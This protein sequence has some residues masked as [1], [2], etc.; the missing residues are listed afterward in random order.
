MTNSNASIGPTRRTLAAILA[1]AL[2]IGIAIAVPTAPAKASDAKDYSATVVATSVAGTATD[3]FTVTFK[4]ET[5]NT[6]TQRAGSFFVDFGQGG[7]TDVS[8]ATPVA[9]GGQSW[10]L[11]S[12]ANGLIVISATAGGERIGVGETVSVDVQATAPAWSL[13][14]GNDKMLSTGGDQ[15]AYGDFGGGNEFTL[16][17]GTPTITVTFDG[18]FANCEQGKDCTTATDGSVGAATAEC[19]PDTAAAGDGCGKDGVVAIDFLEGICDPG[20]EFADECEAIWFADTTTGL[21]AG[22]YFY[23]VI[24]VPDGVRNPTLLFENTFGDLEAMKNCQPPKRVFNCVDIKH[25]DYDKSAGIYP[26]K[27][28]AEDPRV[29]FG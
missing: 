27:L 25:P 22:D 13:A 2:A 20:G 4:N 29:G 12:E 18:Q 26:V 15:Q 23:V 14:G 21:G 6:Y 1:F 28:K 24:E 5:T 7:F 8:A 17:G 10:E 16:Q 3:T 19:K 11:V 9:G